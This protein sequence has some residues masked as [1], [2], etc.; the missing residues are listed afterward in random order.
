MLRTLRKLGDYEA[1]GI[2]NIWLIDPETR[3]CYR[4]VDGGWMPVTEFVAHGNRF[5]VTKSELEALLD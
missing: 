2:R 3:N 5:R 4:I 1:M